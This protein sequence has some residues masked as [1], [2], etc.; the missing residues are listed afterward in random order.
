MAR[1]LAKPPIAYFQNPTLWSFQLVKFIF[2]S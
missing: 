2:I 1:V